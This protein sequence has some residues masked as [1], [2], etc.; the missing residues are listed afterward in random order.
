[1]LRAVLIDGWCV[2]DNHTHKNAQYYALERNNYENKIIPTWLTEVGWITHKHRYI[3]AGL[4]KY[5]KTCTKAV[6]KTCYNSLDLIS[7]S[8]GDNFMHDSGVTGKK[9]CDVK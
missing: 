9:L 5:H 8:W 2:E 7:K 3:L 1:V 4:C 6:A